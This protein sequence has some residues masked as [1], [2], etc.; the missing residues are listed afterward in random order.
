M[1]RGLSRIP[2]VRFWLNPLTRS[3]LAASAITTAA[4]LRLAKATHRFQD[5][6]RAERLPFYAFEPRLTPVIFSS[7]KS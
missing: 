4:L 3:L 5:W 7:V 1:S 2:P 6:S